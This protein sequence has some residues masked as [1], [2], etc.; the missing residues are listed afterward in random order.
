MH[1]SKLQNF[2]L[3]V[4]RALKHPLSL[5]LLGSGL[6]FALL[7]HNLLGLLIL[8]GAA[9]GV[10]AF[11]IAKLRDESFIRSAV[12]EASARDRSAERQEREFRIEEL[13][14]DSRV[15]MKTIV[16]LQN[17][18]AEDVERSSVNELAVGMSD[19]IEVTDGLVERALLMAQKRRDLQH[20]LAKTDKKS[21]E[22]SIS[23][24]RSRVQQTTDPLKQAEIES[25]LTAKQQELD[26][27]NAIENSASRVLDQLDSIEYAFSSLRAKL[28]RLNSTEIREWTSANE[29]LRTELGGLNQS[30]DVLVQSINEALSIGRPE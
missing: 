20:Y 22:N 14:V 29:E 26:D 3:V 11:I 13:D 2:F 17:E 8:G 5:G 28:V 21:I 27:Y 30:V 15:R 4:A 12:Q 7:M 23:N 25:L 6:L 24:L 10:V 9:A 1:G 19:T 16:R 18:I